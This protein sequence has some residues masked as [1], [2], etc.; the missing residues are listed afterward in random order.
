M[1]YDVGYSARIESLL[2]RVY[3]YDVTPYY[4]HVINDLSFYRAK[5]ADMEVHT[6]YDYTPRV[7]GVLRELMISEDGPSCNKL[8]EKN[9][10]IV[11]VFKNMS[12]I[13]FNLIFFMNYIHQLFNLLRMY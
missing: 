2:K 3:G 6:F 11:P 7:T 9:G 10:K 4:M 8:V 13:I 12:L 1:T 5:R